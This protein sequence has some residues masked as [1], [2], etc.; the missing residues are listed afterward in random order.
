MAGK[1]DGEW[2]VL[3]SL[4][5][6]L[7]LCVACGEKDDTGKAM[8]SKCLPVAQ[9]IERGVSLEQARKTRSPFAEGLREPTAQG[10]GVAVGVAV[11]EGCAA[12]LFTML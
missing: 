9:A 6:K 11:G 8:C 1:K 4:R 2:K 12:V 3:T 5:A 7:G 10:G